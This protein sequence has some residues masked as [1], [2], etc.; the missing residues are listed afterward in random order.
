MRYH[1]LIDADDT[2]WENNIYFEQALHA[3][4]IFVLIRLV[5][6]LQ[7]DC[8]FVLTRSFCLHLIKYML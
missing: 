6:L 8:P 1:L 4:C 7:E 3:R 2:L 5:T